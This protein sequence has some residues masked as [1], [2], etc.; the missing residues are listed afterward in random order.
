[1]VERFSKPFKELDKEGAIKRLTELTEKG[2]EKAYDLVRENEYAA[3]YAV[4]TPEIGLR[5][6][7]DLHWSLAH[8]AVRAH[9]SA[10]FEVLKDEQ[11]YGFTTSKG[12]PVIHEAAYRHEQVALR[13]LDDPKLR[14][15]QEGMNGGSVVHTVIGHLSCD[16]KI[17]KYPE[18]GDIVNHHGV[19]VAS[20]LALRNEDLALEMITDSEFLTKWK[21]PFN[22]ADSGC[23][24]FENVA[25]EVIRH[26]EIAAMTGVT[27]GSGK[28][29]PVVFS[30]VRKSLAAS[31][32]VINDTALLS[33]RDANGK[34]ALEVAIT[35]HI[36]VA[37]NLLGK[38]SELL[39]MNSHNGIK[40]RTV[41]TILIKSTTYA[42]LDKD[43]AERTLQELVENFDGSFWMRELLSK[44]VEENVFAAFKAIKFVGTDKNQAFFAAIRNHEE[45]ATLA[46]ESLDIDSHDSRYA[47]YQIVELYESA[48]LRILNILEDGTFTDHAVQQ[49]YLWIAETGI[50]KHES[51]AL[52]VA[53]DYRLASMELENEETV[54]IEPREAGTVDQKGLIY[55]STEIVNTTYSLGHVAVGAFESAAIEV[56]TNQHEVMMLMGHGGFYDH[57]LVG[58]NAVAR[59]ESAALYA[60]DQPEIARASGKSGVPIVHVAA[61]WHDA[62]ALKVLSR[63]DLSEITDDYGVSAGEIASGKLTGRNV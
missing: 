47:L 58:H 21:D 16:A 13:I 49:E 54:S 32:A 4:S 11:V 33:L 63:A 45:V 18:I 42:D 25:L 10:A 23:S 30:A 46:M 3:M 56:L 7:R 40:L 36:E 44:L 50:R 12:W 8:E 39:E 43:G 15:I 31:F 62:A 51:I 37:E 22:I 19:S 14:A 57:V 59:H 60:L 17:A 34:T 1:M 53:R 20:I 29:Y 24:R 27:R 48:A 28:R 2:D 9:Q 5:S 55:F 41:A 26:P 6:D 61:K 35:S 52:R 38:N